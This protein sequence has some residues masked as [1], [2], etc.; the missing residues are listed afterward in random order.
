MTSGNL[1]EEPITYKNHE[2]REKLF[3]LADA[4]L[5]HDRP[6]HTRCDDS[7]VQIINFEVTN[8]ADISDGGAKGG[9]G[10]QIVPIRR[11]RGYAPAPILFSENSPS[12]LAV[13]GELKNT[14]CLTRGAHAFL[15]QHIGD[16]DNFETLQSFEENIRHFEKLFR[17]KPEIIAYDRHPDYLSTRYALERIN[18]EKLAGVDVQHHHA[19]IAACMAE[20]NLEE[21]ETVIGVAFDGTGFGDDGAIWGGE[22]ILAGYRDFKRLAHL[23]Y[24]PLPGGDKAIREPWRMALSWLKLAQIDWSEELPP[25]K[26]IR[27]EDKNKD[28]AKVSCFNLLETLN[29]QIDNHINCPLTSSMGR[30]FDTVSSL[31]GV[32][33]TVNY[34]AQASIE[35]ESLVEQRFSEPYSY[36]FFAEKS[37]STD[38]MLIIDPALM[39]HE[40]IADIQSKVDIR[41]IASRFH[42]T[43]AQ[44]VKD[45]VVRLSKSHNTS[46]IILS[47]GVWQNRVLLE[48]TMTLLGTLGY[49]VFTHHRVPC[50]DGGLALGQAVVAAVKAKMER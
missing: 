15:S 43:I 7:V 37:N 29:Q 49:E 24:V 18:N 50:N 40:I 19:H 8:Q 14:F 34:E 36:S 20:H 21:N 9:W 23:R 3:Q 39:F 48:Q 45:V 22:I 38:E 30:L 12:I 26:Y 4:I 35:L 6:I 5:M 27:S 44:I 11:A 28:I 31:I 46:K 1:E 2:A 47:G 16:L 10:E 17:V 33:Q 25:V 13:G 32:R 41:I 42:T